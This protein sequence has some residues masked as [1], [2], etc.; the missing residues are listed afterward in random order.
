MVN[1]NDLNF[2]DVICFVACTKKKWIWDFWVKMYLNCAFAIK[3]CLL[4]D[5][6]DYEGCQENRR[7]SMSS[8]SFSDNYKVSARRTEWENNQM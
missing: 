7:N 1:P 5:F 4:I 6:T 3:R 8:F 2:N